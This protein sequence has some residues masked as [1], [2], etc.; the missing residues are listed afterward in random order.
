VGCNGYALCYALL[1]TGK[2][3]VK[4]P[5]GL[6]ST[7]YLGKNIG[8]ALYQGWNVEGGKT[9]MIFYNP[10]GFDPQ[11]ASFGFDPQYASNEKLNSDIKGAKLNASLADDK[12]VDALRRYL[13]F[14]Q[15]TFFE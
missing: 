4:N 14:A 10:F 9:Y 15:Y 3:D 5:Q 8:S 11:Y 13:A 7:V 12:A 6:A 1:H 2:V